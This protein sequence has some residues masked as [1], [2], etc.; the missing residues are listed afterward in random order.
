MVQ[1]HGLPDIVA[2]VLA[3]R[4]VT[5]DNAQ[6]YLTPRL[7]DLM[8]DPS[9]LA[10][11]DRAAARI[12]EAVMRGE[13]VAVF[14]DYDVDGACSAALLGSY[15][16]RTDTPFIVRIPDRIVDG[17]GPNVSAIR[18]LHAAG[19]K[20]L[21]TVDCG[22]ASYEPLAEAR[23]LGMDAVVLDHHQAA[24]ELPEA[25]AIVNPNRQ[26]DLSGLGHLC[27][28]GVVFMT[29]VAVQRELRKCGFWH[30]AGKSTQKEPDLLSDLDLVGLAT[31]ADVVPLQGLNRAFVQQGLSIMRQR[32]RPG[33]TA[34]IDVS[35]LS[36]PP[37]AWHLGFLLG[38]RINA[39]GRIG[40]SALGATLLMT[41]DPVNAARI[42]SELNS[43]NAERQAVERLAVEE[44][45]A[46]AELALLESEPAVF[47]VASP[48]WHPGVV[49][50]VAARLKE[51]FNR[52]AFAFAL[53]EAGGG[54][55][56]G[57]SIP[58][59]DVGRAV[60]RAVE[61]GIAVKGGGHAMAAGVTLGPNGIAAFRE[62]LST[63]LAEDV[64]RSSIGEA[65]GVDAALTAGGATPE[66]V[67]SITRAGP[68]GS[69]NPEPVFAF[70]NHLLTDATIV[71]ANH[72]RIRLRAGDG[73][74]VGGM[75]FRAADQP[76]GQALLG[77]KGQAVH[78]A[79]TLTLDTWGGRTQVS[80][81]LLDVCRADPMRQ[82]MR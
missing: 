73:T 37:E 74:S 16:A 27:A 17:Y 25:I 61:E 1:L 53:D 12:A 13:K 69:G 71:G 43:L 67:T 77:M 64:D 11:M 55:G 28:A 50:L 59:V 19:C 40:D 46:M 45:T 79:G 80:L 6:A 41:N 5:V 38:P 31:V 76:L 29:L 82:T 33:L 34:L 26:D 58:G 51:R 52:P 49:G 42:A 72:V 66:L 10:D 54:T 18:E 78:A 4:G 20:L 15:L 75:V 30:G 22:V 7:R 48:D 9:V 21:V 60:R 8:P 56:S 23:K 81:R 47:V 65:L 2:R 68:Y 62:R 44:A 24:A 32:R 36:G 3:A 70:G 57:R 14:G 39:G 35:G 63:L